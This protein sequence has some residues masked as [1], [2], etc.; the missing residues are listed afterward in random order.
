MFTRRDV[1]ETRCSGDG[2]VRENQRPPPLPPLHNSLVLMVWLRLDAAWHIDAASAA[3]AAAAA[4][5]PTPARAER[6]TIH[7]GDASCHL[8]FPYPAAWIEKRR[9]R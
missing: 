1:W 7:V 4:A 5:A 8:L 2:D 6:L 9:G 3:A